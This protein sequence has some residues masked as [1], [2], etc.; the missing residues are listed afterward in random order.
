MRVSGICE[1]A[2][3][4][5]IELGGVHEAAPAPGAAAEEPRA[6]PHDCQHAD[7]R[8]QR[9]AKVQP[10]ARQA[11]RQ[12]E[13]AQHMITVRLPATGITCTGRS[14]AQLVSDPPLRRTQSD[15]D[16][17]RHMCCIMW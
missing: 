7:G 4:R 10:A 14:P 12:R 5:T 16:I 13:T 9:A 8:R 17:E 15:D 3:W 11:H 6:Q 1:R 2:L